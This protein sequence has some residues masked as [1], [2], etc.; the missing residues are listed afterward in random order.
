MSLKRPGSKPATV[1]IP[2]NQPEKAWQ[3]G[4][5]TQLDRLRRRRSFG[6]VIRPYGQVRS[7]PHPWPAAVSM[8]TK[9]DRSNAPRAA[10]RRC[11]A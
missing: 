11:A 2:S 5:P 9:P 4:S 7:P 3:I 10:R 1:P 8:M 6:A